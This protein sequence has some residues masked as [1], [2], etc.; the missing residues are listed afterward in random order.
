MKILIA[1]KK[2]FTTKFKAFATN[3]YFYSEINIL[4]ELK[5]Y[6]INSKM[7]G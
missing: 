1:L 3:N 6:N 7:G 5:Y 2:F 4:L